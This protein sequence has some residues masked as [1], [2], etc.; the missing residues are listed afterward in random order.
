MVLRQPVGVSVLVTPWNFPAAMATR[1]IAPALAAGCTVVL[2]PARETPLTAL[3]VA[4][5]LRE[6][7]ERAGDPGEVGR[8]DALGGELRAPVGHGRGDLQVR[9]GCLPVLSPDAFATVCRDGNDR[10][11]W[12]SSMRLLGP[13]AGGPDGGGW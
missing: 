13:G 9:K 4:G 5:I 7:G 6:A 2:K 10:P 12:L 11:R 1:K 3:A 8:V